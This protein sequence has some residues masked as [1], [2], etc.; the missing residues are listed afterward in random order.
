VSQEA[1]SLAAKLSM[2]GSAR[3]QGRYRPASIFPVL[4]RS[5]ALI[6]LAPEQG[7]PMQRAAG[8]IS[9]GWCVAMLLKEQEG[10]E[11]LT[12]GVNDGGATGSK[13]FRPYCLALF[14]DTLRKAN[15]LGATWQ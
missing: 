8:Q 14:A 7:Y 13:I 12:P 4:R 1:P 9:H 5:D 2:M 11:S 6:S 10:I 3:E 15:R